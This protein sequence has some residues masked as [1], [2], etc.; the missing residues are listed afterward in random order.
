MDTPARNIYVGKEA[1]S[2]GG[3]RLVWWFADKQTKHEK[4][5]EIRTSRECERIC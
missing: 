1:R 3:L 2:G 5:H 4:W